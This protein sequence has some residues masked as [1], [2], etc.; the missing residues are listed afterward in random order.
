MTATRPVPG[1]GDRIA[2]DLGSEPV[3]VAE[4]LSRRFGAIV[5]VD[6]LTLSVG[7]GEVVGL[8]GPNGA[9]KTTTIRMLAGLIAPTGGRARVAGFEVGDPATACRLRAR[10]GILPEEPGLYPDL[11]AVATLEFYARLYAVPKPVRC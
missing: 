8:L 11:S 3:I 6:G 1:G 10:V 2:V 7:R 5:A 4:G 9:G